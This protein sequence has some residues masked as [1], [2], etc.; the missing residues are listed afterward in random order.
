MD[1]VAWHVLE[2]GT[3]SPKYNQ[4]QVCH[5]YEPIR[6]WANIHRSGNASQVGPLSEG[7]LEK[8]GWKDGVYVGGVE[9][10]KVHDWTPVE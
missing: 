5:K 6:D 8:W 7:Q 1:L 3:P 4:T 10:P 2:D 9:L